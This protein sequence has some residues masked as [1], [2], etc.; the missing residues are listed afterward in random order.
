M[1]EVK[2]T[3][4]LVLRMA[5]DCAEAVAYLHSLTPCILHRDLKAEN[6]LVGEEFRCKLTDFGLSRTFEIDS[7]GTMTVVR[8]CIHSIGCTV[9]V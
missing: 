4:K 5:A 1:K 9:S 8:D 7:A 3:W 6:L 2:I